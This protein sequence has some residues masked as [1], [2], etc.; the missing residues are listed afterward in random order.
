MSMPPKRATA[1]SSAAL[2]MHLVAHVDH[3]RQRLAAGA[4]DLLGGGVDGARQLRV[5]FGGLGGDRDVGA[6]AGG[7]QRRSRGRCRARRR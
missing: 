2:T 4:L 6:V 1:L 5:R 7:A 3:Q